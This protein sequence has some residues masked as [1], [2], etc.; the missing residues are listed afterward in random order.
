MAVE[1]GIIDGVKMIAENVGIPANDSTAAVN[2]SNLGVKI[3]PDT[4][5]ELIDG[6]AILL[7]KY[8]LKETIPAKSENKPTIH[9]LYFNRVASEPLDE[10]PILL[11]YQQKVTLFEKVKSYGTARSVGLD[12]SKIFGMYPKAKKNWEKIWDQ[13]PFEEDD[14]FEH[15]S[16]PI[17]HNDW[18]APLLICLDENVTDDDLRLIIQSLV[19]IGNEIDLDKL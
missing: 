13:C 3:L 15:L 7:G 11:L 6:K 19:K 17:L 5:V 18:L 14:N 1:A 16:I 12:L 2:L 8:F 9:R 10:K 4:R